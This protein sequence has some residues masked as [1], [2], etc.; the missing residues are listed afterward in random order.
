MDFLSAKYEKIKKKR[1]ITKILHFYY[2][3]VKNI[4]FL[5]IKDKI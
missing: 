1:S 5:A 2:K 4:D 3:Y